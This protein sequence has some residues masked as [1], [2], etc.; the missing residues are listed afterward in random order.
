MCVIQSL[1][2]N[3]VVCKACLYVWACLYVKMSVSIILPVSP[4]FHF[5]SVSSSISSYVHT[6]HNMSAP[7]LFILGIIVYFD[8]D[9]SYKKSSYLHLSLCSSTLSGHPSSS[10][11]ENENRGAGCYGCLCRC[12]TNLIKSQPP[13]PSLNLEQPLWQLRTCVPCTLFRLLKAVLDWLPYRP[14]KSENCLLGR[15]L[16]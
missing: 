8:I 10:F 15:Y 2:K 5:S 1:C 6:F 13:K 12:G 14:G 4:S 9:V 16:T 3:T 11:S 7:C